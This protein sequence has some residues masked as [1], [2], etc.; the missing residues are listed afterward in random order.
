LIA[1]QGMLMS[2]S[3]R[4]NKKSLRR[5]DC[6][7]GSSATSSKTLHPPDPVLNLHGN[8]LIL[9]RLFLTL[10]HRDAAFVALKWSYGF[11]SLIACLQT[12]QKLPLHLPQVIR[13]Q[14]EIFSEGVW[15]VGH[16]QYCILLPAAN[17]SKTN[18]FWH[19]WSL[20]T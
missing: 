12:Q 18:S 6:K 5:L 7:P 1:A 14:P 20:A 2:N 13:L 4:L 10:S 11:L 16:G 8:T 9:L 3:C 17:C 19:L 15:H